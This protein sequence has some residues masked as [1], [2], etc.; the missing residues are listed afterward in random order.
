MMLT[1]RARVMEERLP[2]GLPTMKITRRYV[3][4]LTIAP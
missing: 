2:L 3:A 4:S 1:H